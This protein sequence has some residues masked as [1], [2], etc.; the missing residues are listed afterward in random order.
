MPRKFIDLV[1]GPAGLDLEDDANIETLAKKF[2]VS[3]AAIRFR[4]AG[5]F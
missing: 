3:A 2:R 4:L 1:L 5:R